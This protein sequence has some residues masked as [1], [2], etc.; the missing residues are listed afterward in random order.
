M[1]AD[2]KPFRD[3][4]EHDVI[5]LFATDT[6]PMNKGTVVRVTTGVKA[7]DVVNNLAGAPGAAYGNTV[8][9]RWAVVGHVTP[10]VSGQTALG[11]ALY[12]TKETDENGEKYIFNPRKA[13]EAQVLLSGQ[14]VPLVK[15]GRFF[16]S[17]VAGGPTA[18]AAAYLDDTGTGT[19]SPTGLT[20]VGQFLGGKDADG[21]TLVE[22]NID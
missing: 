7:D 10:W 15:R 19:L 9:E 20:R 3:Y 5:N 2:L 8:S 18:G 14:P 4:D 1:A 21:W 11:M 22:L 17:G 6:I 16:L 12:D 13:K